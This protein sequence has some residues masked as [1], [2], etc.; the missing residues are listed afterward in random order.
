MCVMCNAVH[1]GRTLLFVIGCCMF[2]KESTQSRT[3]MKAFGHANKVCLL[4]TCCWNCCLVLWVVCGRLLHVCQ[5][6]HAEQ[7][8]RQRFRAQ[9]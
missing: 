3:I 9:Q 4:V 6:E 1:V 2:A 7:G 8:H 5:G